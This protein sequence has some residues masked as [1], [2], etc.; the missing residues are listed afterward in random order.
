[1]MERTLA[2]GEPPPDAAAGTKVARQIGVYR[3]ERRLGEGGMAEVWLAEQTT[4]VR[5]P[6]AV[7]LIKAGMDSQRV[8][9][10]FEAERQTLALMVHPAIARV[11]DGGTTPEGRPYF[12]M[13]YVPGVPIT[14]HCDRERLPLRPRLDLF[15]QVCEG[16]HHAHQKAI[17]HRDLKP[18]NVLV[19]VV[20]GR[21]L[22]KIIDFGIAKAID[23]RLAD[24]PLFTELG[25]LVGTPEYMSPEQADP[26][27]E[28]IDTRA[29][30]YSLGAMLYE[31]LSGQLPFAS[32]DLR[33]SSLE[34][35]RRKIRDV[36]PPAPSA[37]VGRTSQD[38]ESAAQGR[39]T[40][41]DTLSRELRGDLDAIAMKALEKER[42][43]RY[44]SPSEL[45]ADIGRYLRN[46]PVL[47]RRAGAGYRLRK[48][49]RRNRTA[50]VLTAIAFL[51]TVAGVVGTATQARTARRQRDFALGQLSRA[52]A[53]ND[54]NVFL[55]SD[56]APSGKP[57][58]A[59][60]LLARAEHIIER[61]RSKPDASGVE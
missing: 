56:A 40:D 46:E 16:V 23:Q 4:P 5:R 31:L 60:Q 50:T 10:R 34:E 2:H 1:M 37:R 47:A 48:Y 53:I 27:V 6:V 15:V 24:R 38:G 19:A 41:A 42:S 35:L 28:D 26:A 3:L 7:K 51:A 29:D 61:Q 33:G 57:F 20:D 54:L 45:A 43:R 17:I 59:T 9:A 30:V 58:T 12:V 49:V 18:S 14:E 8:L 25:S 44:G 21:P 11:Y 39:Q 22:P 52:E 36:D 32:K 55:L 13:E